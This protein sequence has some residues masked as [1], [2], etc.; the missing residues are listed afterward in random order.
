MRIELRLLKLVFHLNLPCI[1]KIWT[2]VMPQISNL[3]PLSN[4]IKDIG[5]GFFI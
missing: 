4:L 5:D 1:V 2:A 3:T